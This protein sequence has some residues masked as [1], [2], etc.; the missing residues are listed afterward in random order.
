MSKEQKTSK[1][2]RPVQLKRDH[3]RPRGSPQLGDEEIEARLN[4]LISPATYALSDLYHSLGL[5]WRILNLPVMVAALLSLIWR[6]VPSVNVLAQ[7]LVREQL[8]WSPPV[9]VSQ[10]ALDQRLRCLPARLF[11]EVFKGVLPELI[12]RARERTRPK[13]AVI[14]RALAHFKGILIVDATTLEE[15]FKKVGALRGREGVV[16]AG[17]LT[18][19]LDLVSKLPLELWLD[20]D[21][22]CNEKSFLDRIKA[23]LESGTLLLLD[24][25]F[26]SFPFFDWLTDAT[27]AF[28][29]RARNG[30]AFEVAAVLRASE[31]V[32]DRIITMGLYRSNPCKHPL[33]LVEVR[34][35]GIWHRYLTNVLDPAVLSVA[36]VCDLYARR[37]R[38][39]EAF[40]LSK[41][42]L[43]LSYLWTGANNGVEMQ[44]WATWM[45]YAVL[46]DLSDQVAQILN[47]PLDNISQEMVYRGLYHFAVARKHG[48]A[49]DPAVYLAAQDDLGIVKRR[50]PKRE[51]TRLDKLP[52]DLNL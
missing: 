44:V 15:L 30:A 22:N 14:V 10:Q 3:A 37:W 38:I 36:D 42:L 51:Q 26:Y 6:Q 4:E 29:T 17:K 31:N 43:N 8:L 20:S 28:I 21:P 48:L 2:N 13:A 33:R 18:S 27:I 23:I 24:R 16:L 19:V 49:S 41:R 45:F 5:R 40:C 50:R 35:G 7:M 46:V 47:Q 39:E 1:R 25:G 34:I 9:K 12:R 11:G 32:R 52:A